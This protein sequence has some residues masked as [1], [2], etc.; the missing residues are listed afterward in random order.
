MSMDEYIPAG[1]VPLANWD[2]KHR[3][4]NDGHSVEWKSLNDA[5]KAGEIA[6]FRLPNGR[7]YVH[8]EQAAALLAKAA[9]PVPVAA[10]KGTRKTAMPGG[11]TEAAVVALC[12][13]NNGIA[14]MLDVLER[15]T[16]AVEGMA[17]QPRTEEQVRE[18]ITTACR[19]ADGFDNFC[20]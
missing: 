8:Q 18:A 12:E 5:V 16:L 10:A 19:N 15:L 9:E 14:L 17:T 20:S 13:I 3:G 6:G 2:H 11:Q 1:F 7:W 4:N